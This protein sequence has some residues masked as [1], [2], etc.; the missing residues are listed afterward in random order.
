[1]PS[2]TNK[3]VTDLFFQTILSLPKNNVSLIAEA[4]FQHNIWGPCLKPH[5]KV[6]DIYILICNIEPQKAKER[7]LKRGL[8]DPTREYFHGDKAV[9]DAR[10]GKK[11]V[12]A[13]YETPKL[14]YP[15]ILVDTTDRYVP[16]IDEIKVMISGKL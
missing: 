13:E 2:N 6:A 10:A 11:M 4:A 7:Y 8:D 16:S 1:L 5:A 14:P 9:Q 12:I 15:T 3:L